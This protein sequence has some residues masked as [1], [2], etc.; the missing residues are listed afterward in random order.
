MEAC[1]MLFENLVE[2]RNYY[3]FPIINVQFWESLPK[4]KKMLRSDFLYIQ[5]N[6]KM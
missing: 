5:P 3:L 2:R 4:K 6:V 1:A